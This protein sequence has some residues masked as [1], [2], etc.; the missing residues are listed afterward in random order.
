MYI[1]RGRALEVER[2]DSPDLAAIYAPGTVRQAR[3]RLLSVWMLSVAWAVGLI[4]GGLLAVVADAFD[5]F[6]LGLLPALDDAMVDVGVRLADEPGRLIGHE[7]HLGRGETT[8]RQEAVAAGL[9]GQGQC[10]GRP[11]RERATN[12]ICSSSFRSTDKINVAVPGLRTRRGF[13]RRRR[14]RRAPMNMPLSAS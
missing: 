7:M 10:W 2:G 9:R 13:A 14:Q 12:L 8:T 6:D 1:L 11:R 5:E 4:V 3:R